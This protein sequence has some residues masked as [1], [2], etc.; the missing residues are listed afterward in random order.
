[1]QRT[2]NAI[3]LSGIFASLAACAA[4]A[5]FAGNDQRPVLKFDSCAKPMYPAESL[6][7]RH[8]G[9]VTLTFNVEADGTISNSSVKKSSGYPL[10]DDAAHQAIKKCTFQPAMKN[11]KEVK[12]SADI[13]YVWTLTEPKLSPKKS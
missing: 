8:E 11:G 7:A 13:Q 10:M 9:T 3:A 2:I 12:G 5:A 1:M 4:P 6:A